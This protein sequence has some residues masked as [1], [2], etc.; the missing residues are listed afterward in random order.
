[1]IARPRSSPV[2]QHVPPRTDSFLAVD[3][4]APTLHWYSSAQPLPL[5]V[6]EAKVTV[7]LGRRWVSV[8]SF[9]CHRNIVSVLHVD[10]LLP[11]SL[12]AVSLCWRGDIYIQLMCEYIGT[13]INSTKYRFIKIQKLSPCQYFIFCIF[14]CPVSH[15]S[16]PQMQKL[17]PK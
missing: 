10:F 6:K 17:F 4:P 7:I 8:C 11:L 1:M 16:I 9:P 13:F 5:C 2:S 3:F 15:Y 14:H 12:L